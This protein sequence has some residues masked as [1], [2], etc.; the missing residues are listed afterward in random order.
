MTADSNLGA[1][2]GAEEM[3]IQSIP[4]NEGRIV[5][6]WVNVGGGLRAFFL[7]FWHSRG[8][9]PR[10]EALLEAVLEQARKTRHPWLKSCDANMCAEDFEKSLWFQRELMH[11]AARKEAST[12]RSKGPKEELIERTCD[13]VVASG[14]LKG[15]F[16]QMEVWKTLC[17]DHIMQCPFFCEERKRERRKLRNGTSR[18]CRRCCLVTVEEGCQEG[19][20]R[21]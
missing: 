14:N 13:Y 5:Q 19:V 9:T 6:A 8:W 12:R 15:K 7:S 11:V 16:P 4:S 17:Q 18:S 1:G 21:R 10:T 20:Q 3:T 2:V